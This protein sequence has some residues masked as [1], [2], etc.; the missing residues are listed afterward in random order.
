MS[1]WKIA[2]IF[3]EIRSNWNEIG[4]LIGVSLD[5]ASIRDPLRVELLLG[6]ETLI[7]MK[8]HVTEMIY[9]ACMYVLI[10][11]RFMSF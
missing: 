5:A 8:I 4:L 7:R 10:W 1:L 9:R 3:S 2:S 6:S 11:S